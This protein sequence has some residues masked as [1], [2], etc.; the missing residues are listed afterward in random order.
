MLLAMPL[1]TPIMCVQCCAQ[2]QVKSSADVKTDVW[3]EVQ[4]GLLMVP[5]KSFDR[6]RACASN[7]EDTVDGTVQWGCPF[8]SM[9]RVSLTLLQLIYV[10]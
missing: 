7:L 9:Y 2:L 3:Q 1:R 4:P 6:L 8:N 5:L 10:V